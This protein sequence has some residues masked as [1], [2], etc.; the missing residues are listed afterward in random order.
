MAY[1]IFVVKEHV[2]GDRVIPVMDI[3]NTRV[4]ERFW[5]LSGRAARTRGLNEGDEV[6]FYA[7]GSEG[8]FFVGRARLGSPPA[9]ISDHL[10]FFIRGSPSERLTHYVTLDSPEIWAK[11][12]PAE[13]IAPTLSFVKKKDKWAKAFRG[14]LKRITESDYF[15]IIGRAAQS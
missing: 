3:L 8:R 4:R 7:I 15:S 1:W 10:R 2:D 11:S 14:S 9:P 6:I 5:L 12:L 13:E